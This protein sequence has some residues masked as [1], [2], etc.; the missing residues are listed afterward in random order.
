MKLG[1]GIHIVKHLGFLRKI[2]C[3]IARGASALQPI[4][5]GHERVRTGAR[6]RPVRTEFFSLDDGIEVG[7]IIIAHR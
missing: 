5:S 1:P 4:R 7:H 6:V 2:G 3:D